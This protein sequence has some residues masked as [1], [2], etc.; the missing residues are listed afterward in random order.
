MISRGAAALVLLLSFGLLLAPRAASA[1]PLS[2]IYY[3]VDE[4]AGASILIEPNADGYQGT[5]FDARGARQTF[6]GDRLE[7]DVAEAVLDMDERTVL[8]RAVPLPFG[9]QVTL[10]PF[11][12]EGR[13]LTDAGRVLYFVRRDLELP[14]PGPDFVA[15]PRDD[16]GRISANAFLA[17]YEF[18]NATGVRN[19][20]LS[21]PERFRTLMR[22]FPAVQLD[23]IWKLCLAPAADRA[24]ALALRGQGVTCAEV[25]DGMAVAQRR[26]SFNDYKREVA[27]Q[28]EVLRTVVRCADRY[29]MP[30]EQCDEAS[31]ELSAQAVAMET[32]AT[33]LSRYR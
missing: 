9:I 3:G 29:P 8:M 18:W 7:G 33:I 22:L 30:R 26:G 32:A 17:S 24:L 28:K 1:E 25:I 23:V 13:L 10:V 5:F 16:R 12:K 6:K 11:D 2:G 27:R 20:Y 31:R 14:K 19:G 21:L 4:A 15:A